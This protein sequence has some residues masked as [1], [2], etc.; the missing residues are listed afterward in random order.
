MKNHTDAHKNACSKCGKKQDR[1][2]RYCKSC[3]AEYMRMWR[4]GR[5]NVSREAYERL[6][7]KIIDMRPEE[8]LW[9]LNNREEL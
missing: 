9:A 4:K 1:N 8:L 6:S 3:H 7:K 2:G 5:V